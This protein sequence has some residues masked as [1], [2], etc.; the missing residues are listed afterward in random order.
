MRK[1]N[2]KC[3]EHEPF[4]Y[5]EGVRR[6]K[7]GEITFPDTSPEDYSF[8]NP[9]ETSPYLKKHDQL[10]SQTS[11]ELAEVAC[12]KASQPRDPLPVMFEDLGELCLDDPPTLRKPDDQHE[13]QRLYTLP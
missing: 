1:K 8:K 5:P 4:T 9:M 6:I 7:R 11:N 3:K 13:P 10:Q 12:G 2:R